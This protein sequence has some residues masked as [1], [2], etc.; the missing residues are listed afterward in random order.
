M[1]EREGEQ[2]GTAGGNV[3]GRDA[4]VRRGCGGNRDGERTGDGSGEGAASK[5]VRH[6]FSCKVGEEWVTGTAAAARAGAGPAGRRSRRVRA[7]QGPDRWGRAGAR[8][9]GPQGR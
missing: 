1:T 6:C 8:P 5:G 7:R 9:R 2:G 4:D 3:I